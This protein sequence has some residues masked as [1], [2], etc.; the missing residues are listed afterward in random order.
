MN[1]GGMHPSDHVALAFVAA[2]PAAT[3]A[4]LAHELDWTATWAATRLRA[5]ERDGFARAE[6]RDG[7]SFRWTVTPIGRETLAERPRPPFEDVGGPLSR[8]KR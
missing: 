1:E 2:H 3:S 6:L 7:G 5:L 8:F 4:Q